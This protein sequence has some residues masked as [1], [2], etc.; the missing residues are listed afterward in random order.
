M[1]PLTHI[2]ISY[3]SS[4]FELDLQSQGKSNVFR[5]HGGNSHHKRSA[6]E[7]V[8]DRIWLGNVKEDHFFVCFFATVISTSTSHADS[9]DTETC[10]TIYT[11]AFSSWKGG[12]SLIPGLNPATTCLFASHG[13]QRFGKIR[14]S[15]FLGIAYIHACLSSWYPHLVNTGKIRLWVSVQSQR[16]W[17]LTGWTLSTHSPYPGPWHRQ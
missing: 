12:D 11:I 8:L 16:L 10:L 3:S 13:Q 9:T 15:L 4:I 7:R 17:K 14:L 2:Y 6:G 5:L 1:F